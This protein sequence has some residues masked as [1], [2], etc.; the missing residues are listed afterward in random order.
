MIQ[1][2]LLIF[3]ECFFTAV[4]RLLYIYKLVYKLLC[5]DFSINNFKHLTCHSNPARQINLDFLYEASYKTVWLWCRLYVVH[6]EQM[7][8]FVRVYG[9]IYMTESHYSLGMV[10]R[11]WSTLYLQR[12]FLIYTILHCT[13]SGNV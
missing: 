1:Y 5:Y 10:T 2:M 6:C 7:N 12:Q 9:Y 13:Y 11:T 4:Q 3:F 8:C